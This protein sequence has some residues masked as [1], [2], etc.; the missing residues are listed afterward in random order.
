MH[1]LN[2]SSFTLSLDLENT[3]ITQSP[4][5]ANESK[6][7][8]TLPMKKYKYSLIFLII[9]LNSHS[10][11][12]YMPD[13]CADLQACVSQLNSG[14]ELIIRDG[15]YSGNNNRIDPFAQVIP[16]GTANAYTIIRA[17]ND[18]AVTIDG[19][20]V[21]RPFYLLGTDTVDGKTG[22]GQTAQEYIELRGMISANSSANGINVSYVNHIK[23]INMG[24]VDPADG[25]VSGIGINYS[26]YVLL[27]G[28]YA[29]GA[30]RYKISTFHA[31]HTV[32]RNSVIRYDRADAQSDPIGGFS[33]Y[34]STNMEIQNCIAIDGDTSNYWTGITTVAGTFAAPTTSGTNNSGPV[35]FT[36]SIS[37]NN[38]M[39][40][41]S[42]D[43]NA[44]AANVFFNNCIGWDITTMNN[45]SFIHSQGN[46]SINNCTFGEVNNAN[47]DV[48]FSYYNGWKSGNNQNNVDNI[49]YN[50]K[51]G[52]LFW[53]IE[54]SASNN[55]YGLDAGYVID[56]NG[57]TSS[58]TIT[59]DPKLNGLSYLLRIENGSS[60]ATAGSTGNQIG[61]K[62]IKMYGKPG[63]LWGEAGY[64]QLQDGNNG[65][66]DINLWPYPNEAIIKTKMQ[67]YSYDFG[68]LTGDRGFASSSAKQLNG[69]DD[70]TLTSYIWEYLGN[71]CPVGICI[72]KLMFRNGFE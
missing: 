41:G 46:S 72:S 40:F 69:I 35:N 24:A 23:L 25:N 50:F 48:L 31:D 21:R 51:N 63:T 16:S 60:L 14:D 43:W 9:S 13:D 39:R 71:A 56:V 30:G 58:A 45:N 20:G 65:Q 37:L 22:T 54:N 49:W 7:S 47:Q 33:I 6:N 67:T 53:N 27:E 66:L 5:T 68:N 12:F 38:Q 17:E 29:W 18:G 64:D 11:Q 4:D 59:T 55:I 52:G 32:I 34:S 62:V 42:L 57:T 2:T 44:Y 28:A 19:E 26:T 61:A 15:I 10:A 1:K 36:N 70:V 3:F 8:G